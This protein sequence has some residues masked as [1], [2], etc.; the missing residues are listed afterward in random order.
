MGI[1]SFHLICQFIQT[2]PYGSLN[3]VDKIQPVLPLQWKQ[4]MPKE[5]NT[6]IPK[7][8][9]NISDSKI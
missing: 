9:Q 1:L 3:S 8:Y 5:T 2:E 7:L 4:Y 6:C